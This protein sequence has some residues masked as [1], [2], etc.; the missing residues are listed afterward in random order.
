MS[1][2]LLRTLSFLGLIVFLPLFVITFANTHLIESSAKGVIKEKLHHA[3]EKKLEKVSL[4]ASENTESTLAVLSKKIQQKAEEKIDKY[5]STL[6]GVVDDNL[7]NVQ[8]SDCECRLK[9]KERLTRYTE[10][11]VK[12]LEEMKTALIDFSQ[13]K[14]MEIVERLLRDVRIV[15]GVNALLF[16][17]IFLISWMKP[18][19]IKPLFVPCALMMISSIGLVY[20]YFFHQN[21]FYTLFFNDFMGFSYVIYT[22]IV[23]AFI[24]DIS[25]NHARVTT[26]ISNCIPI[27]SGGTC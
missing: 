18:N 22:L 17:I 8:K 1:T 7:E 6:L 11:K 4:P 10:F 23:V 12:S 5:K 2:T 20:G 25:L 9:W 27:P 13:A 19:T 26:K 15:F 16:G 3:I 24:G 14:Y 21:W